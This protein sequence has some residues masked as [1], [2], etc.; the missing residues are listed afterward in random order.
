ME[1]RAFSLAMDFLSYVLQVVA[2]FGGVIVFPYLKKAIKRIRF[3]GLQIG[4][5]IGDRQNACVT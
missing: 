2:F 4:L 3:A 1:L 5:W